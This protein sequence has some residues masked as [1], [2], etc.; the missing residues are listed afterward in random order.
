[1]M[2][3]LAALTASAAVYALGPLE[4]GKELFESTQLG[5]NGKSC[6]TCHA[7]GKRLEEVVAY[8]DGELIKVVNQC[9]RES[10]AGKP[11]HPTSADMKAIILYLRSF[12]NP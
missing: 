8:D 11:P 1:M 9:I 4:R 3:G 2:L 10:L 7:G 12:S 6:A 5:T